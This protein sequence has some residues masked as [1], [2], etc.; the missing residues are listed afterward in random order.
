MAVHM[1]EVPGVYVP[2]AILKRMEA[3]DAAGNGQ[4]EGVQIALELIEKIKGYENQGIHG[5]HIMPVVWEE[6]VPRIV[7]E[8][9]LLP[10]EFRPSAT[11]SKISLIRN[12]LPV[13]SSRRKYMTAQLIDGK[14]I[15]QKVRDEVAA[16]GSQT[17]R[18]RQEPADPGD[19]AGG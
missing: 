3:A 16:A 10:D 9:G 13:S 8:A 12:A 19:G 4:E 1:N 14:A 5:L 6:I 17:G 11:S 7:T 2:E 18:S 15:A